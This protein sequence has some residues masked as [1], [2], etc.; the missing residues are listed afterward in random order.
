MWS[1]SAPSPLT[2]PESTAR[3][4]RTHIRKGLFLRVS[5]E[6]QISLGVF[7]IIDY[8]RWQYSTISSSARFN[9]RRGPHP[10]K[11]K[12]DAGHQCRCAN[13]GKP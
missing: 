8:S 12:R 13:P 6:I 11:A 1:P 5:H 3:G 2:G 7:E 9:S 10:D 4:W